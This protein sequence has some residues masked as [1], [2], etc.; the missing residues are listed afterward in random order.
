[1]TKDHNTI[2]C[3]SSKCED[4]AILLGIRRKDGKIAFIS[5]KM[6]VNEEFV[7]IAS[8]DGTP[9]SKFRFGNVCVN[10]S[11]KQWENDRCGVIDKIMGVVGKIKEPSTLP[12]CSIREQCRW[13][14]QIGGKACVVCPEIITDSREV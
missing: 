4:G 3:P 9:E 12:N 1:M 2:F 7:R 5:Q 8:Q 11:C 14:E 6:T 10:D 13:Y